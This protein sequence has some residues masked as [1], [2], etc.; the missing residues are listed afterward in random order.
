MVKISHFSD[1]HADLEKSNR[2]E[3]GVEGEK[4]NERVAGVEIGAEWA[5]KGRKRGNEG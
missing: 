2:E 4:R 5:G 3:G 1:M